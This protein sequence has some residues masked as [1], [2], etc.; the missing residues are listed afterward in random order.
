MMFW[1]NITATY[2]RASNKGEKVNIESR[3]KNWIKV[4]INDSLNTKRIGSV[5]DCGQPLVLI[6]QIQRAGGSLLSQLFDDH[7]QCNVY[8]HELCWGKPKKWNWP[9]LDLDKRGSSGLFRDLYDPYIDVFIMMGYFKSGSGAGGKHDFYPFKFNRRLQKRLFDELNGRGKIKSQRE[10]LDNYMTAFFNAWIDYQ[11]IYKQDKRYT[12]AFTPRVT[13][14]RDSV[15]RFF[16]D[17][18]DGRIVHILRNPCAWWASARKHG[19]SYRDLD[20]A[21]GLWKKNTLTGIESREKY[22]NKYIT[23]CFEDLLTD[24]EKVM[25][26]L[27][28]AIGIDFERTLLTPTFNSMN[29]KAD[30]SFE[31]KGHGVLKEAAYRYKKVL[32]PEQ[33]ERIEEEALELYE[34]GLGRKSAPNNTGTKENDQTLNKRG[35][36]YEVG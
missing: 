36:G 30:S 29:M 17:Y 9:D 12:V 21:L 26:D 35:S 27:C 14:Y 34:R 3:V 28:G 8:P 20:S 15:D 22:G 33:I 1:E 32:S 13:S 31:V 25:K 2:S 23:V 24:T 5:V 11:N 19:S 18:P 6:S 16:R 7:P 10:A 4:R